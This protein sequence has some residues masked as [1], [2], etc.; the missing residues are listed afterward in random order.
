MIT[1][2][3]FMADII[4]FISAEVLAKMPN[5]MNKFIGYVGLGAVQKNPEAVFCPYIDMMRTVGIVRNDSVDVDMLKDAL[6]N[7]F[8]QQPNLT[9]AGFSFCSSDLPVLIKYLT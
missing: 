4:N 7:G 1:T 9:V 6:E 8:R 3:A 5:G 2:H